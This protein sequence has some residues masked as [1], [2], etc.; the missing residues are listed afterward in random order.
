MLVFGD[1]RRREETGEAIESLRAGLAHLGAV[2]PGIERHGALAGWLIA[3]GEIEQALLDLQLAREG[4]ERSTPLAGRLSRLTRE[5]A[6]ALL[7][8]FHHRGRPPS[9]AGVRSTAAPLR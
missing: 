6:K 7:N 9:F 8:S 2:R 3:A 4:R 1:A 5:L